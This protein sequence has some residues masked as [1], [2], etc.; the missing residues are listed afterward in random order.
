QAAVDVG[1]VSLDAPAARDDEFV[2]R[3]Q[4]LLDLPLEVVA[5]LHLAGVDRVAETDGEGGAFRDGVWPRVLVLLRTSLELR[6]CGQRYGCQGE[7]AQNAHDS[8]L[9]G[10]PHS[11]CFGSGNSEMRVAGEWLHGRASSR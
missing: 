9:H 11:C 2:G 4:V 10:V 5:A 3:D 6:H 7:D 8:L 1:D